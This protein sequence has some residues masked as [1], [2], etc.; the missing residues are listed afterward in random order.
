VARSRRRVAAPLNYAAPRED[1]LSPTIPEGKLRL[2]KALIAGG[3]MT[4]EMVERALSRAGQTNTKMGRALMAC[5]FPSEAELI[6]VVARNIRVPNVRAQ[7]LKAPPEVVR[8][9]PEEVAR[10]SRVLAIE[11]IGDIL[12]VVTPDIGNVEAFAKVRALTGCFVAPIRCA[13]EG[14]EAA[15]AALYDQ[16]APAP[17]P[18]ANANPIPAPPPQAPTSQ[19]LRVVATSAPLGPE[20]AVDGPYYDAREHFERCLASAGPM[21]VEPVT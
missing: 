10:S 17:A 12:V 7:G 2:G 19:A 16:G 13:P 21:P 3:V 20:Q 1:L 5:G 11:R 6:E 14:F 4:R 18:T 8:A 9:I 15:L